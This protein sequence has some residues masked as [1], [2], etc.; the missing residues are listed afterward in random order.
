LIDI[1]NDKY[2]YDKIF[3]N[4]LKYRGI[5]IA[6]T[7]NQRNKVIVRGGDRTKGTFLKSR[8]FVIVRFFDDKTKQ[9]HKQQF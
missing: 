1:N 6:K 4:K 3:T 5:Y 2:Q 8:F 9:G 7:S